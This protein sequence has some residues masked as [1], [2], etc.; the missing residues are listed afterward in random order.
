MKTINSFENDDNDTLILKQPTLE[1]YEKAKQEY[2]T[3]CSWARL[4]RKKID[5]LIDE[6]ATERENELLYQKQA[7]E[8]HEIITCYEIYEGTLEKA[9][10]NNA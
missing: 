8:K 3:Y 5:E 6:L 4:A 1:E 10:R 2:K 7:Q 9:V